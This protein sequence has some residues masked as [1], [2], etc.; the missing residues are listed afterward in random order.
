MSPAAPMSAVAARKARQQQAQNQ[1]PKND[2]D[3]EIVTEPPSKK[4]RRS[5]EAIEAKDNTS[6]PETR[7]PRTRSS[8]K[9]DAAVS[10]ETAKGHQRR[11]TRSK[12]LES[13][14]PDPQSQ[15]E[16]EKEESNKHQVD[17][18]EDMTEDEVASVAGEADGYESPADTSTE[19]QNFPLSKVRLG[20][21]NI[22]YADESTLCVSIKEKMVCI[23]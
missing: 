10:T 17:G 16:F 11:T 21:S 13:P 20:K 4:P 9:Q 12:K 2:A 1:T 15:D 8:K 5:V 22:V 7:G 19:I 18:P 3:V 14:Q 6:G 23:S